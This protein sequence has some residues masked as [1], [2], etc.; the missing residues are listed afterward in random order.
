MKQIAVPS[1]DFE[2]LLYI[3]EFCN[4]FSDYL[5]TSSYSIEDLHVALT[6]K[7]PESSKDEADLSW[8]DQMGLLQAK[9]KGLNLVNS[10]HTALSTCY[11]NEI[12]NNPAEDLTET[13]LLL[14]SFDKLI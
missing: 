4:N 10:I 6:F 3:W 13:E 2:K 14:V 11:L 8:E 12:I 5:Q 1:E 7:L 9:E